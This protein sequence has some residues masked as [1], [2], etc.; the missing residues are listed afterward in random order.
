MDAVSRGALFEAI[1]AELGQKGYEGVSV[2]AALERSGVSQKDFDAEFGDSD[3]CLFAAY[4]ELADRA[5]ERVRR[6]CNS[7][8][9]WPEKVGV[10][11]GALLTQIAAQPELARIVTRD[12]PA[13]SPRAYR[14][15][16]E[17]VSKFAALMSG[18]RDYSGMGDELPAD[19][20]LLAVGAAESL[21]FAE[22]DAGRGTRLPGMLP[23]ILFSV[24]VPFLGPDDAG[25]AMRGAAAEI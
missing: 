19:V 17:L 3:A 5:V 6:R 15:Y 24:L 18:G 25:E 14:S 11:L 22:V 2:R 7:T 13:I 1:L 10:G 4:Q 20:E 8:Q 12:F 21:I 16:T 9:R 23:E